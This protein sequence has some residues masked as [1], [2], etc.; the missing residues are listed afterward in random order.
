[1]N[2]SEFRD[3]FS[4]YFDGTGEPSF[5]A[6]ADD[7]L[8]ECEGCRRYRDVVSRGSELLR[9]LAPVA[10]SEDFLPRLQH[11]IYHIE[12]GPAL[13]RAAMSGSGTTV[14]AALAVAAVIA[15]AAWAP[16]LVR[17]PRVA[18]APVVVSRPEPRLVGVR[19]PL[20][21]GSPAAGP[22]TVSYS[23]DL[24]PEAFVLS[25]EL[26]TETF[27]NE[28]EHGLWDDPTVFVRYSPLVSAS[29]RTGGATRST[30]LVSSAGDSR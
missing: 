11:R 27:V 1:M 12:D 25:V 9:D 22:A 10:V 13:G 14:A 30:L 4:D 7:H 28:V 8:A 26:T 17:P 19:P 21:W 20:L 24:S 2:C 15:L 18:L 3:R 29:A 6:D 5:V 16:V 23:V